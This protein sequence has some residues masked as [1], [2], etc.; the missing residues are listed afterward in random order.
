MNQK[1]NSNPL[2]YPTSLSP[3]TPPLGAYIINEFFPPL[4]SNYNRCIST[5]QFTPPLGAYIINIVIAH[6]CSNNNRSFSTCQSKPSGRYIINTKLHNH[7]ILNSLEKSENTVPWYSI[8]PYIIN[9]FLHLPICG[10]I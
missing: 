4:Y 8:W 9:E 2:T 10:I 3:H 5:C 7:I 6:F 1:T